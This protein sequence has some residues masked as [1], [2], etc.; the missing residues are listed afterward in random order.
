[1]DFFRVIFRVPVISSQFLELVCKIEHGIL[2]QF[3]FA[4]KK[5]ELYIFTV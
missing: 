4:K 1:V 2:R 3:T 5:Q